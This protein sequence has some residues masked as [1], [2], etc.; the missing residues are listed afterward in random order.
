[1]NSLSSKMVA[2]ALFLFVSANAHAQFNIGSSSSGYNV[3]GYN[4]GG[5]NLP[6]GIHVGGVT[7]GGVELGSTGKSSS[8]GSYT[9]PVSKNQSDKNQKIMDDYTT[10]VANTLADSIDYAKGIFKGGDPKN[11]DLMVAGV[12]ER[13]ENAL[14][15][16]EAKSLAHP[17]SNSSSYMRTHFHRIFAP[18]Y[19]VAI[20]AA[21]FLFAHVNGHGSI[22]PQT[23]DYLVS[24]II[25]TI[26]SS[27]IYIFHWSHV[28]HGSSH[29]ENALNF[30]GARELL[31]T[32]LRARGYDIP[33]ASKIK[34]KNQ[35]KEFVTAKV[36]TLWLEQI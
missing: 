35:V 33:Q 36:C 15:D 31:W 20:G 25:T 10:A 3:G 22:Q 17:V 32:K 30:E 8:G 1:M 7:V 13:V 11:L 16:I 6:G 14:D 29:V 19:L 34:D 4:V 12:R 27:G 18:T 9:P 5:V 24:G 26:I 2:V 21:T 28:E 23:I